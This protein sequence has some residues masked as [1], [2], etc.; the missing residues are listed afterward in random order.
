MGGAYP[1]YV[2]GFGKVE[3][4]QNILDSEYIINQRFDFGKDN[5]LNKNIVSDVYISLQNPIAERF[6]DLLRGFIEQYFNKRLDVSPAY[7][8]RESSGT[9][10][11]IRK[12]FSSLSE[13]NQALAQSIAFNV[14][15]YINLGF[16]S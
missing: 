6:R 15:M 4:F 5:T 10:V 8:R 1:T 9:I 12:P 7:Q 16:Q 11:E 2:T 14:G 13:F 3:L